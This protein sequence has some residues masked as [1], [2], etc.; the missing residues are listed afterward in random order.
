MAPR[1]RVVVE[2]GAREHECCGPAYERGGVVE[3]TCL[4]VRGPDGS[5]DRHVVTHHDLTP[6]REVVTIRGRIAD[7]CVEHPDGVVEEVQRL[8]S[9]RALRGFDDE[10][11]GHLEQPWTGDLVVPDS[12]R[13]LLTIIS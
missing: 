7:V 10:D 4:V 11:D 5:P 8:P 12:D 1:V 9:G 3:V 6:D 13:Y 2:V